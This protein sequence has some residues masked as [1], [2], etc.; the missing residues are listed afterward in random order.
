MPAGIRAAILSVFGQMVILAVL[1]ALALISLSFMA[2]SVGS[3]QGVLESPTGR[4]FVRFAPWLQPYLTDMRSVALISSTTV[5][6]LT[7]LRNIM[8]AL[9]GATSGRLGENINLY[10]GEKILYYYLYSPYLW[11]LSGDSTATLHSLAG[12]G[13]LGSM[14]LC[15][16]NIYTYT[17]ISVALFFLLI[18]ATP[19]VILGAL[20]VVWLLSWSLYR[21]LKNSLDRAGSTVGKYSAEET[22]TTLNAVNGIREVLI[23][24]QQPVFFKKFA[25]A[26]RAGVNSRTFLSIA[27]PIPSW[28]LE[29]AAFSTI[30][31]TLWLMVRLYDAPMP[32]IAAVLLMIM[33]AAWRI[34][35]LF[36]RALGTIM[37]A[38]GA[39]PLALNC[40]ERLEYIDKNPLP[41]PPVPDAHFHFE[42]D[43]TLENISFRYANAAC[44]ALHT[45]SLHIPKGRQVGIVGTSGAGKS[46]FAGILS[47]LLQASSG[48]LRVDGTALSPEGLAAYTMTVGYVPQSPY[49][50]A[51]T[52]AE[53][54]AFSQWGKPW[55]A[56]KVAAACKMAAL[57]IVEKHE[58]G[59]LM[60]L[61]DRGAGLS[62][63]QAQR[64]SIARALY[65]D[66]AL[67]ILDEAT[68]ALDLGTE[69]AI[70]ET[71][72]ALKGRLTTIIIAH[73]LSTVAGC[74]TV[75]WLENGRLVETGPPDVV[76][77]RYEQWMKSEHATQA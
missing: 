11:H 53:N 31:I 71:I 58:K 76:L 33:L 1:E 4:M 15:L 9:V 44:D 59:I 47:G 24:R 72:N 2:M 21:A 73:R 20:A 14:V 16:M 19:G 27:P 34:L 42:R 75:I 67:L 32:Q 40:L 10:T 5:V 55:D 26:C 22:R 48:T 23:Y 38:R 8:T 13:H 66:P 62:G 50:M 60:P 28:V 17:V 43:I 46:T 69:A 49:I 12:R 35:P 68:S 74:D 37:A 61:G 41:L 36:N 7:L 6:L 3:P 39:R 30:P 54:V 52:I 77:P 25:D 57:D 65:A 29:V 56:E 45:L 18:E 64:V 63:G 51:G 70:M